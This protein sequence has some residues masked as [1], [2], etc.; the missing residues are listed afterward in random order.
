MKINLLTCVA[1]W[2]IM[3]FIVSQAFVYSVN[4]LWLCIC[5]N[6]TRPLMDQG[7]QVWNL[8]SKAPNSID[9]MQL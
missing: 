4:V 7:I 9:K 5:A 1:L 8:F 6:A 2:V 3:R